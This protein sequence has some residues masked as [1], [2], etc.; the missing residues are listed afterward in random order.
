MTHTATLD[1][2]RRLRVV[3][4]ALM[5]VAVICVAV[6]FSLGGPVPRHLVAGLCGGVFAVAAS[7]LREG[8]ARRPLAILS[9]VASS[10]SIV[11][12]I[13]WF[14]QRHAA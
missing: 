14:F 11:L 4:A 13:W 1:S 6:A 12:A 2:A 10:L 3:S 8:G 9:I 7:F 5:G